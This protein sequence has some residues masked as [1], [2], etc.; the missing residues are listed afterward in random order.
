M[1]ID[2][3]GAAWSAREALGETWRWYVD[4]PLPAAGN[5]VGDASAAAAVAP[6]WFAARVPG[7]VIGDLWHAG[8]LPDP[9]AG[10]GSRLAEWVAERSWVYRRAVELPADSTDTADSVVMLELDGVDPGATVFWDGV[11]VAEIDGI[12]RC[13][14]ID[15]SARGSDCVAP[16]R[17]AL[18]LVIHPA[19][20][21]E[22][23]VG[24]TERVRVHAPRMGYGW[25]FCPRLRHQGIWK[26]VR[27]VI[28][29][30]QLGDVVVRPTLHAS[31]T[32][33]HVDVRATLAGTG[34][35]IAATVLVDLSL[36]GT[37]VASQAVR[38]E[39]AA[40]HMRL[41]VEN[42]EL[43][44]PNGF[45]AQRLYRLTLRT[46]S[47]SGSATEPTI[48]SASITRMLGFRHAIMAP[49]PEAPAGALG[50]TAVINGVTVPLIGWNWVP[51]D[52]LYGQTPP[53]RVEHLVGLAA[54]S[55][56]RLLRVWGGGLIETERFY[57]ACDRA[58]LMVW[59]EFSQSSSGMQSAPAEDA[60]F[61][62]MMAE[63]AEAIVPTLVHHPSLLIW[64]GG[65]E[66]DRD[67]VPLDDDGSSVLAAL[68][69]VV[70]RLD[71]GRAWLPT[72]P[73]GPEFH[74]R[75]DRIRANPLGQHD[76]HGPWEHQG[77]EA[78]YTLYNA[79]SSLAHTEFGVE[80][81]TNRRSLDA[82]IPADRQWPAD[83]SNPL[84]R[85]LGEWWNNAE[86]VQRSFG[87]RLD[88]VERMRWA[89]QW[90]QASGLQYAIEA[91]RRRWPRCSMILPWQ[92]NESYPNAWC[93]S[94]LDF[95]GDPKPA[96]HA[97]SRA[98]LP[99]RV[100]IRVDRLS[101][102]RHQEA[103]AE[104]W[105]WCE[106]GLTAG[107]SVTLRARS[108]TGD[109]LAETVATVGTVDR[110]ILAARL[111]IPRSE[112]GLF[113]WDA[114]WTTAEGEP[115]DREL[116]LATTDADLGAM[117][118][119]GAAHVD[120]SLEAA[121]EIGA[122][123]GGAVLARIRHVDGPAVIG[124]CV[125]DPRPA[126]AAGRLVAGGDSR[127]LL[128]GEERTLRLR[129]SGVAAGRRALRIEAWNLEPLDL[130][131]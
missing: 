11:E 93:T 26:S 53:E 84:Y 54:Q 106:S 50:Y 34:A 5:S 100:S 78:H 116:S 36:D 89:S 68:H 101:W 29:A 70:T 8:Q 32:S 113:L 99:R 7:A 104:A 81:M 127:P 10:F 79:G 55:G 15:L 39:S 91:D 77:L 43:W 13:A 80:G 69:E 85:H 61:V 107:S 86:L 48:G 58:G 19:P 114:E 66:L 109:V 18:A 92:L 125:L 1:V 17:H 118:D 21:S 90:M 6:A 117:F 62:R 111:V 88:G 71:A 46:Q 38:A 130:T 30:V 105:L 28:D 60:R 47:A 57:E 102:D 64:G 20:A 45:G 129:W 73:T 65:N 119:L 40:V 123:D 95:L 63:E 42:P 103:T 74:N 59:Q 14:R 27:I 76:V 108:L 31:L 115:L 9:R 2:L 126:S 112:L 37:V 25:D 67:G 23:Q 16:G 94:A 124:L 3:D 97:V 22:S 131:V 49:N 122:S 44:W 51:A 110:P 4:A 120:V 83:R 98:F 128:P 35:A 24:R 41:E 82:L 121:P 56:A 72:S 12:Y 52:A 96:F 75:L 87:G 33:A